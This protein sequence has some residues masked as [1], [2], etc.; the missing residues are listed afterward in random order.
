MSL[1]YVSGIYSYYLVR[2]IRFG[3]LKVFKF[4]YILYRS[5][6]SQMLFKKGV[7]K[8]FAI[9]SGK[10]LCWS[11]FLI[12]FIK[13]RLQHRCF[14]ANI[15]KFCRIA[16]FIEQLQ[17][18]LLFVGKQGSRTGISLVKPNYLEWNWIIQTATSKTKLLN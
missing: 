1:R 7:L 10:H 6:R 16:F 13:K 4:W 14:P 8:N 3:L 9:F 15:V 2:S 18:L 12:N 11:L 5:S 17:W